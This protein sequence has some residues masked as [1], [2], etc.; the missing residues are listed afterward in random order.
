M[1]T[2]ILTLSFLSATVALVLKPPSR[3]RNDE[4]D[5]FQLPLQLPDQ[6]RPITLD[7][8]LPP[9]LEYYH[10]LYDETSGRHRPLCVLHPKGGG[11]LDDGPFKT[12]FDKCGNGGVIRLPDAN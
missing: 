6:T 10:R 7:S 5:L 12:A 2:N 11:Q 3:W 1:W 8:T 4:P 9:T